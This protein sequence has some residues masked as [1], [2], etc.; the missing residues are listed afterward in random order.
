M[1]VKKILSKIYSLLIHVRKAKHQRRTCDGYFPNSLRPISYLEYT[2]ELSDKEWLDSE[3]AGNL[4][5]NS[6]LNG[7]LVEEDFCMSE[8]I[9]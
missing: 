7:F 3:K 6:F 5:L 1:K 2:D 9:L 8:T 4:H